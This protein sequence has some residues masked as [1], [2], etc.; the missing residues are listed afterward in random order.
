MSELDIYG[1]VG[2]CIFP[3]MLAYA[4]TYLGKKGVVSPPVTARRRVLAAVIVYAVCV[5]TRLMLALSIDLAAVE[6]PQ[7]FEGPFIVTS[8]IVGY[9]AG[10]RVIAASAPNASHS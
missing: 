9:F 4:A 1:M 7:S 8:L 6:N 10:M 5:A 3:A 2:Q